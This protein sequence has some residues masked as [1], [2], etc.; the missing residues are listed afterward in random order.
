MDQISQN[1]KGKDLHKWD[2]FCFIDYP[3]VVSSGHLSLSFSMRIKCYPFVSPLFILLLMSTV[4]IVLFTLCSLEI[5]QDIWIL[6]KDPWKR[7]IFMNYDY[8][9]IGVCACVKGQTCWSRGSSVSFVFLIYFKKFK[10][11]ILFVI[12]KMFIFKK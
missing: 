1:T 10:K 6:D 4:S 7:I 9:G 5:W 2:Y 3:F 8:N 12:L 11:I